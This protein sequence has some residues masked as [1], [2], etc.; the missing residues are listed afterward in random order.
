M[1]FLL[2]VLPCPL[3]FLALCGFDF[4]FFFFF[5]FEWGGGDFPV[6]CGKVGSPFLAKAQQQQE[7]RYPAPVGF[8]RVSRQSYCYQC[9]GIFNVC[10]AVDACN[11]TWELYADTV[12]ESALKVDSGGGIPC[13]TGDSN[14]RQYC[15]W[16]FRG[17]L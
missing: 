11:C 6:P 7:Q 1:F 8:F 16:L 15:A 2:L 13:R 17:T 5:F 10:T 12:R 14:P 4:F 9:L 3:Q